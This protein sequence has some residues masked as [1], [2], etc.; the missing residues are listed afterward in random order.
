MKSF[1]LN[2]II[3]EA[4]K[5]D[6]PNGDI[7][8][9]SLIDQKTNVLANIKAKEHGVLCGSLLA[10]QIFK[11]IDKNLTIQIKKRDGS[12]VKKNQTIMTIKGKKISILQ[13]ERTA[14]NFLGF[15]SGI[16]SKTNYLV[17]KTKKYKTKI[18]CTRKTLP[19]LRVLQKYA[20]RIGG[21]T[22]NRM[23]L[24]DEIFIKDNHFIKEVNFRSIVEKSIKNNKQ[25]KIITVEVD[26]L[27][28]L[29]QIKDLKINRVLFDNMKPSLITKGLTLLPKTVETEASGNI[30]ETNIISYAKTKVK[31]ISMGSLTHSI[32]NFDFS[33]EIKK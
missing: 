15:M 22:N 16:A 26:N 23:N 5:E 13:A 30:N 9:L 8:S 14:L 24:S 11:K 31:R 12:L 27:N 3:S 25:R 17:S 33:L 32:R 28:Q 20:V 1:I 19:N 21:G 2:K 7:T 4:I 6:I 10:K 29:K 18:C